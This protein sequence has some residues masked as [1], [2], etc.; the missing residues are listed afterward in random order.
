MDLVAERFVF[1]SKAER[2]CFDLNRIAGFSIL[3]SWEGW[4]MDGELNV[5]RF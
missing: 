4:E 1:D 3:S 2:F 5:P